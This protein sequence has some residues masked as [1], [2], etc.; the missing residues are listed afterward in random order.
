MKTDFSV[1][2]LTLVDNSF[3]PSDI[4]QIVDIEENGAKEEDTETKG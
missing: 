1:G 4:S 2:F 3:V